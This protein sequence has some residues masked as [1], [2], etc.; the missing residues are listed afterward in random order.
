MYGKIL[1]LVYIVGSL[2]T[3]LDDYV[4]A[5]DPTYTYSLGGMEVI[6]HYLSEFKG[7]LEGDNFTAFLIDLTSQTWM[8]YNQSNRAV[9]KHWLTICLPSKVRKI[10]FLINSQFEGGLWDRFFVH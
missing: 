2:S 6:L 3:P 9:W 4:N 10:I 8:T 7:V 1:F 5:P